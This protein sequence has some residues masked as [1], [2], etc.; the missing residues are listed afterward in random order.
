LI[1]LNLTLGYTYLGVPTSSW[2]LCDLFLCLLKLWT[3][4]C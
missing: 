1:R 3:K 2:L 4:S